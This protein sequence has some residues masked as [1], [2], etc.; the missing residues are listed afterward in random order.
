MNDVPHGD[1]DLPHDEL[2]VMLENADELRFVSHVSGFEKSLKES[3]HSFHRIFMRM[4]GDKDLNNDE[5]ATIVKLNSSSQIIGT[6]YTRFSDKLISKCMKEQFVQNIREFNDILR[7]VDSH[8]LSLLRAQF[9]RSPLPSYIEANYLQLRDKYNK[10]V[11]EYEG[12]L[13]KIEEKVEG[14]HALT[15]DRVP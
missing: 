3:E 7:Q 9:P 6:W 8:I 4:I 10:A 12:F 13:E 11:T 2:D 5:R 15:F 1:N 14:I